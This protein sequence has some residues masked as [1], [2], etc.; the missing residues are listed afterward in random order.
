MEAVLLAV[1]LLAIA[2][3]GMGLNIFF[4]KGKAFPET[5]IGKNQKMRELGLYCT[6]CEEGRKWRKMKRLHA[7][8]NI[9]PQNLKI[10]IL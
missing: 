10:D 4:R 3:L 2:F 5:E 7:A 6:K 9:N 8:K 1:G